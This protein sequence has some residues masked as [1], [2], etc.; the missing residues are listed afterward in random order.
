MKIRTLSNEEAAQSGYNV[1]VNLFA[2][3][4]VGETS[5]TLFEILAKFTTA[6]NIPA[7]SALLRAAAKVKTAF[8]GTGITVLTLKVG[9]DGDDD[10]A[11]AAFDLLT[12]PGY[13][14]NP[15]TL[16]YVFA[17]ANT[18]DG[19]ATAT[20]GALSA[21]TAGEVDLFFFIND[22]NKIDS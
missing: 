6:V 22:L 7:G 1:V 21:L 16:P 2:T 20:G 19:I 14:V 5:G 4:L 17:A 15:S 8:A 9:D 12:A 18:V 13:F 3:D 11:M 10:R